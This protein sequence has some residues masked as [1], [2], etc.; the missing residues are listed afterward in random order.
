MK[1][2]TVVFAIVVYCSAAQAQNS[3]RALY[4]TNGK[5]VEVVDLQGLR[6]CSV[7]NVSGK[8][9]K[10]KSSN[11]AAR[12]TLK[13]GDEKL[14][15]LIPLSNVRLD[16]KAAMFRHLVTKGNTL[17]VAGYRCSDGLPPTA[18]SVRRVY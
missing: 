8:V 7:S 3:A 12:I 16:D 14:E 2:L 4:S 13:R 6:S 18:F 11:E 1:I 10:V 15:F 17:E 5:L 9:T